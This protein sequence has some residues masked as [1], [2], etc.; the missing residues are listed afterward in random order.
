MAGKRGRRPSLVQGPAAKR[1]AVEPVVEDAGV[2]GDEVLAKQLKAV[3]QALTNNAW[4]AE[5]PL[6]C[7]HM[8][9]RGAKR[10][11]SAAAEER[12]EIQILVVDRIREL[13]QDISGRLAR[14][15]EQEEAALE[16]TEKA[17]QETKPLLDAAQAAFDSAA[18]AEQAC[19]DGASI[20]QAALEE[21]REGLKEI[22][23]RRRALAKELDKCQKEQQRCEECTEMARELLERQELEV[24]ETGAGDEGSS[25]QVFKLARHLVKELPLLSAEATLVAAAQSAL[26]IAKKDRRPFDELSVAAVE[27]FLARKLAEVRER[28][29]ALEQEQEDINGDLTAAQ[30]AQE[31]AE[32][33]LAAALERVREAQAA[34]TAKRTEQAAVE[35]DNKPAVDAIHRQKAKIGGARAAVEAITEVLNQFEQLAA[36]SAQKDA[37]VCEE[38]EPAGDEPAPSGE[39]APSEESTKN[40]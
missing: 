27:D 38:V 35:A 10:A 20:A 19:E 15:V 7:R 8:L 13:L 37:V 32:R 28:R 4:P 39:A 14:N 17:F 9:A 6:H 11:L 22:A 29:S 18:E 36:R 31:E 3:V 5:A 26:L 12:H 1:T 21:G 30:A 34:K 33:E 25:Q 23:S 16:E 2:S 40:S 24:S